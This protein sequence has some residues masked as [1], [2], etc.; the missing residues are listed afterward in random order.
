MKKIIISIILLLI[1]GIVASIF[2]VNAVVLPVKIKEMIHEKG[3]EFFYRN[4][5]FDNI[6]YDFAEG[7]TITGLTIAKKDSPDKNLFSAKTISS[8][9]P[10]I[11][12]IK[13]KKIILPQIVIS[14]FTADIQRIRDNQWD[15]SDLFGIRAPSTEQTFEILLGKISL[16]KGKIFVSD[17]SGKLNDTALTIAEI[18]A[19]LSLPRQITII[20]Q[21]AIEQ[22]NTA[23]DLNGSYQILKKSL[24]LK[25][26]LNNFSIDQVVRPFITI[27]PILKKALI[28]QADIRIIHTPE[29]TD[30][31]GDIDADIHLHNDDLDIK[32]ALESTGNYF[33]I[34]TDHLYYDAE[35][36]SAASFTLSANDS[37][38]LA[39][40]LSA[41]KIQL[42]K[43]KNELKITANTRLI[44]SSINAGEA[45]ISAQEIIIDQLTV[46]QKPGDKNNKN[47][48]HLN[49][50]AQITA[51]ALSTAVD[52]TTISGDLTMPSFKLAINNDHVEAN[53][54]FSLKK[55]VIAKKDV[56][57]VE[58]DIHADT[59]ELFRDKKLFSIIGVASSDQ[60][61][62][63][64]PNERAGNLALSSAA[65]KISKDLTKISDW[66]YSINTVLD[67]GSITHA[68]PQI[69]TIT[70]I[71]GKADINNN[72]ITL[73]D[74]LLNIDNTAIGINGDL[75]TFNKL[76]ADLEIE[77]KDIKTAD[78]SDYIEPYLKPHGLTLDGTS[79]ITVYVSG[80]LI[81]DDEKPRLTIEANVNKADISS[82][83][84]PYQL[85][86]LKGFFKYKEDF[87][88]WD[89]VTFSF[90]NDDYTSSGSL[91]NFNTPVI[92]LKLQRRDLFLS[93]NA[94]TVNNAYEI[95][96]ATAKT[97]RSSLSGSGRFVPDK[98]N[99]SGLFQLEGTVAISDLK[100][101][102]ALKEKI[103]Q[104][105]IQ[106]I[107][108][109]Q[110]SYNGPLKDPLTARLSGA[111]QA[112]Y[113]SIKGIR[114]D[115]IALQIDQASPNEP[116]ISLIS[117]LYGGRASAK[118]NIISKNNLPFKAQIRGYDINVTKLK[119]II[120]ALKT[121]NIGGNLSADM[122]L[123]GSIKKTQDI[124][125]QGRIEIR[126]GYYAKPN[127]LKGILGMILNPD[128][129][130]T[131]FTDAKAKLFV[132]DNRLKLMDIFLKSNHVDLTGYGWIDINKNID[133]TISPSFKNSMSMKSGLLKSSAEN[134]LEKYISIRVTG[135]IGAPKY[136]SNIN[137]DTLIEGAADIVTDGI[138][139]IIKGLGF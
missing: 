35:L 109:I 11:P 89:N 46:E 73:T 133:F 10:I 29:Q 42:T 56:F 107:G 25:A 84:Y 14:G 70:N 18:T 41:E 30:C 43:E 24:D 110:L 96:Y 127:F 9:I 32:T 52:Q 27:P 1:V 132:R 33:S 7:I 121:K 61:I 8:K 49:I 19:A 64:M 37:L 44:P 77:A 5:T 126:D 85:N 3:Q 48:K 16:K 74:L 123:E 122:F 134:L 50:S 124:T 58:G 90:Q 31:Q 82:S 120:P 87:L 2:Y 54:P 47:K 26:T 105:D 118:I 15:F 91:K 81:N 136:S 80:P 119:E 138:Q 69:K 108:V 62:F 60:I 131:V 65:F 117:N 57:H 92:N 12:L 99:P 129:Q 38:T 86:G 67:N 139:G 113:T 36:L 112:E 39:G 28:H 71:R 116:T 98:E 88:T 83:K 114:F 78:F 135:K 17:Q 23:F 40:S 72:N 106:G 63:N 102:P 4:V 45:S 130:D 75:R 115:N 97:R 101:I 95:S 128:Y 68:I 22:T 55:A 59:A 100:E 21:G 51:P 104:Y 111:Y 76:I 13:E 125:G 20:A 103:D 34:G 79:D 6:E 94:E 93:L 137:S 66:T 53:V